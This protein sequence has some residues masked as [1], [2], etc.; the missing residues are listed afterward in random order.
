MMKVAAVSSGPSRKRRRR[1]CRLVVA[2][3]CTGCATGLLVSGAV[4]DCQTPTVSGGSPSTPG[5]EPDGSS[6]RIVSLNLH[7]AGEWEVVHG[8][9]QASSDLEGADIFLLQEVKEDGQELL[10]TASEALGF[11]YLFAPSLSRFPLSRGRV[12]L[13]PRN[14]LGRKSRC[15]I[16]LSSV[17]ATDLGPLHLFNLHLDT[18]INASRRMRQVLP[19][20]EAAERAGGPSVIAGDFNTANLLWVKSTIPLPGFGSHTRALRK[21]MQESGFSTPFKDTGST[22]DFPPLKLDWIFLKELTWASRGLVPLEFTDHK[23]LWVDV[24]ETVAP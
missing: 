13:L 17:A 8:E 7:G 22:F 16:A 10:R 23:A 1:L 9:L 2:L 20:I 19:V 11:H 21:A 18:R 4:L 6:L 14:D 3:L 5:A 15:R 12:T 24:D